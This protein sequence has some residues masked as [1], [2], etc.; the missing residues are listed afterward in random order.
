MLAAGVWICVG[1]EKVENGN[2]DCCVMGSK[3]VFHLT[4]PKFLAKYG[5]METVN[6]SNP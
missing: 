4:G 5:N 1:I 2:P 3:W 6:L